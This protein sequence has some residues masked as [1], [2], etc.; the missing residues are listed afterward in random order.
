[1]LEFISTVTGFVVS[2]ISE[3]VT[4]FLTQIINILPD[5]GGLPQGVHDGAIYF[6]NALSKLN[7]MLPV[8]TLVSCLVIIITLKITLYG[9]HIAIWVLNWFRGISTARF[10]GGMLPD[11]GSGAKQSSRFMG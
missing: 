6:G 9:F 4:F 5:G 8:D 2:N 11:Y 7:F 1:M 3:L 10:D